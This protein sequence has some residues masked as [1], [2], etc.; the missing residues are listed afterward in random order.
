MRH[1]DP[2]RTEQI[3]FAVAAD[4]VGGV[5]GEGGVSGLEQHS[6]AAAVVEGAG[7]VGALGERID[8]YAEQQFG[9]GQ[10]RGDPLGGWEEPVPDHG[11]RAVLEQPRPAG[12]DHHGVADERQF[13]FGDGGGDHVGDGGV[14]EHPALRPA[15]GEAVEH[16]IQ[17][18]LDGVGGQGVDPP[19]FGWV[20]TG[21]AG[22]R[23][24]AVDAVGVEGAQ[25]GLDARAAAGVA[26]RDGQRHGIKSVK[27]FFGHG[28]GF[29]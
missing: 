13:P 9:F 20:L 26:A 28:N 12:G 29:F 19:H 7:G 8:F 22:D 21:D 24:G 18:A 5:F 23:R 15:H 25:I 10:V 1:I 2:L 11:D 16:G 17:L 6:G 27:V 14:G 3:E 4:D